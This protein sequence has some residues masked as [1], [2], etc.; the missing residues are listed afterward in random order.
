MI[1][2]F[3]RICA[4]RIIG[5]GYGFRIP[6]NR[7]DSGAFLCIDL[8]D[9]ELKISGCLLEGDGQHLSHASGD[10]RG[11]L[12]QKEKDKLR[13]QDTCTEGGKQAEELFADAPVIAEQKSKTAYA[14]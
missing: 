5:G 10:G 1:Q 2:R 7:L 13:R 11:S 3:H 14:G 8:I 6:Q 12:N 9:V 4:G